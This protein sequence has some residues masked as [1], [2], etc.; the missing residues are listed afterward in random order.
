[1]E[2]EEADDV[3][4]V[5]EEKDISLVVLSM[6]DG[7]L[8]S[9]RRGIAVVSMG[10]SGGGEDGEFPRLWLLPVMLLLEVSWL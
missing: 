8:E 9:S 2:A 5:T 6:E 7:R 10:G 4:D 3:A 1:M